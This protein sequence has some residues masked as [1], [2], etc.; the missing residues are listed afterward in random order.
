ML[1][2]LSILVVILYGVGIGLTR[3]NASYLL[4]GYNTMSEQERANFDLDGYLIYHRRFFTILALSSLIIGLLTYFIEDTFTISVVAIFILLAMCYHLH[5]TRE[6]NQNPRKWYD[7]LAIVIMIGSILL[8]GWLT[9][10]GL[11]PDRLTVTDNRVYLEGFYNDEFGL[12]EIDSLTV[13]NTLPNF[14]FKLNGLGMGAIKKGYFRASNGE[15]ALLFISKTDNPNYLFILKKNGERIYFNSSE[16]T[17]D[18]A[19]QLINNAR[20]NVLK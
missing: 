13:V 5:K 2:I 20:Y 16:V 9:A 4:S 15:K 1:I 10:A 6:F 19:L 11:K 7:Y 8:V 17:P 12:D 18:M 3:N 14:V